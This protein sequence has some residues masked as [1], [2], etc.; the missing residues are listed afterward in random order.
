MALAL[1]TGTRLPLAP[2]TLS[3]CYQYRDHFTKPVPA[4]VNQEVIKDQSQ[5]DCRWV[6]Q[7]HGS[8][9]ENL[10]QWNPSLKSEGCE[11][12]PGYSYCV[13]KTKGPENQIMTGTDPNCDCFAV[14]SGEEIRDDNRLTCSHLSEAVNLPIEK[15]LNYNTWLSITDCDQNLYASLGADSSRAVCISTADLPTKTKVDSSL[16]SPKPP[17]CTFD[18]D[19]GEYVCPDPPICRFDPEKGEYVC[20]KVA[21]TGSS[22]A[23]DMGEMAELR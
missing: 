19:K 11:L 9:L 23:E 2:G 6:A 3:S 22:Q 16:T 15:I 10:L 14:V 4:I 21:V 20:P 5:N 8:T 1:I 7:N 18:P 12:Q 13:S 17:I